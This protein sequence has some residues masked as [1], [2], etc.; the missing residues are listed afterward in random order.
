MT[1]GRFRVEDYRSTLPE[2]E[3]RRDVDRLLYGAWMPSESV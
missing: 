3:I 2:G 1:S